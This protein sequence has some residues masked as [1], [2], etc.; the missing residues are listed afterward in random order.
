MRTFL[1]ALLLSALMAT[2][3]TTATKLVKPAKQLICV[4]V[5]DEEMIICW[6]DGT[7]Q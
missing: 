1:S 5:P 2:V 3:G 6:D 7:G 4:F